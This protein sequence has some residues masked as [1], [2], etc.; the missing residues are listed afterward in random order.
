LAEASFA[1]TVAALGFGFGF[2]A[3]DE[4]PV[5]VVLV[6]GLAGNVIEV[7]PVLFT[8]APAALVAVI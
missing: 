7:E 2:A 3:D 6:L 4:V 5:V 1:P 8:V